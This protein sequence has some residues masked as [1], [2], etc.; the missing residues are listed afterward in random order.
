M[1]HAPF[2]DLR[3]AMLALEDRAPIA[4]TSNYPGCYLPTPELPLY[5]FT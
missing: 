4:M 2:D 5:R 1:R 3:K